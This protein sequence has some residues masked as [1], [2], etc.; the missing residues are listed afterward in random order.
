MTK[1]KKRNYW[2]LVFSIC[3]ITIW[4]LGC[5]F[6]RLNLKFPWSISP[7]HYAEEAMDMGNVDLAIRT[8]TPYVDLE[9]NSN[10]RLANKTLGLAY[11]QTLDSASA[12]L[13]FQKAET[14]TI[15]DLGSA[16]PYVIASVKIGNYRK[17]I[18]VLRQIFQQHQSI[19]NP[20]Q[21][22]NQCFLVFYT[23]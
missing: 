2:V 6:K 19:S 23:L 7:T 1:H 4:G 9:S 15:S 5:T 12:T 21:Q 11:Y 16:I 10:Y 3:S 22:N 8:L 20:K 13:H 18:S 17:A 14:I